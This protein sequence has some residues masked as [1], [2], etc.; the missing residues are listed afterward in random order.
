MVGDGD[1]DLDARLSDELDKVNA[2]AT[3]DVEP[4]RE[5]TVRVVDDAGELTAGASGWTWGLAA[6]IAM[7]WVRADARGAGLGRQLLAA[8]E[9]EARARGCTH[10]FTTSFTFQTPGFYERQGYAELFR[11]EDLPTRGTGDVHLRKEL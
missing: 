6:G 7:T 1:A 9:D 8:F 5:L 2:A 11:W 3:P 4:A 10:V